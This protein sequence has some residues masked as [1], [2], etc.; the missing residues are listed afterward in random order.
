MN[1]DKIPEICAN[2][3]IFV[4]REVSIYGSFGGRKITYVVC[5]HALHCEK[6]GQCYFGGRQ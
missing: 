2:C 4:R 6:T 3:D 1:M 5:E